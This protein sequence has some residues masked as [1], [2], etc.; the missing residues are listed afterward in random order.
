MLLLYCRIAAFTRWICWRRRACAC[1]RAAWIEA[2]LCV[3]LTSSTL[4]LWRQGFNRVTCLHSRAHSSPAGGGPHRSTYPIALRYRGMVIHRLVPPRPSHWPYH[5]KA[6]REGAGVK[7]TEGHVDRELR[8]VI[9]RMPRELHDA[10]KRRA[11]LEDLS[12]AQ[13]VRAA[14]RQYLAG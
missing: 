6:M 12:M 11:A 14:V 10:I 9:V 1:R 2:R 7:R 3:T 5:A 8:Q 4:R 13:A